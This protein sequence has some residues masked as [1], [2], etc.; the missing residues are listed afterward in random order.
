MVKES[1]SNKLSQEINQ[2]LQQLTASLKLEVITEDV[3]QLF[4]TRPSI[5]WSEEL[6]PLTEPLWESHLEK[7]MT[8]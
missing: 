8:A 2:A 5:Q 4:R 7:I 1:G 3:V 6:D